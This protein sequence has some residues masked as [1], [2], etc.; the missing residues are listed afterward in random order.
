MISKSLYF[1]AIIPPENIRT[2][3]EALKA[4]ISVTF[5]TKRALNSP[6]HITLIPPFRADLTCLNSFLP[7]LEDLA[8]KE[9]TI[10]ISIIGFGA[11]KPKVIYLDVK[12]NP[13]LQSL[14]IQLDSILSNISIQRDRKFHITLATR[15]LTKV[16]FYRAWNIY[17]YESINMSF[18]ADAFYLLK[19]NGTC[20]DIHHEFLFQ[21]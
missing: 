2:K 13:M 9:T 21:V 3:I 1:I 17:R 4:K 8:K 6:P 19:H 15:D 11:F 18:N 10:A 12:E 20:W 14:S 5:N 16:M 7:R